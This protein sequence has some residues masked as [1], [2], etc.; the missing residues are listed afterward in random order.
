MDAVESPRIHLF[1]TRDTGQTDGSLYLT[2]SSLEGSARNRY[3][4]FRPESD[5]KPTDE[6]GEEAELASKERPGRCAHGIRQHVFLQ[7]RPRYEAPEYE[8]SENGHGIQVV[9]RL[10]LQAIAP[11]AQPPSDPGVR[12]IERTWYEDLPGQNVSRLE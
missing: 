12:G 9:S 11:A 5:S 1:N 3:S 2:L 4:Y 10:C 7:N 8:S 6:S